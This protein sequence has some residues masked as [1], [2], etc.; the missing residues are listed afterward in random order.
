M[1][2]TGYGRA[3]KKQIQYMTAKLLKLNTKITQD[4]TADA[5]AVA[6]V[7]CYNNPAKKV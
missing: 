5:I 4:D 3:D 6:L 1:A 7:H 2:I